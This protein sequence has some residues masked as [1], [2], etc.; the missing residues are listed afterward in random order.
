[1]Q[2][3]VVNQEQ[4][5]EKKLWN[6]QIC[7]QSTVAELRI[8]IVLEA[9]VDCYKFISSVFLE[10]HDNC[11]C[12]V[13][14]SSSN[15][16]S[17]NK[18][19]KTKIS[20]ILHVNCWIALHWLQQR[21]ATMI[22]CHVYIGNTQQQISFCFRKNDNNNWFSNHC[23]SIGRC[24]PIM[25][26]AFFFNNNS[27][28]LNWIVSFVVCLDEPVNCWTVIA[29]F[30]LT[31]PNPPPSLC[32]SSVGYYSTRVLDWTTQKFRL[33]VWETETDRWW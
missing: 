13:R 1:M 11:R 18:N 7:Q 3:R 14:R 30:D 26:D 27:R 9:T 19:S 33:A 24:A 8:L 2:S 15:M 20:T 32:C 25:Y 29:L 4:H 21:N 28:E 10:D 17:N 16:T 23:R 22:C 12:P 5:V 31:W 6:R